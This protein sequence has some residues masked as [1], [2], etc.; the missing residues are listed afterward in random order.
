MRWKFREILCHD[1]FIWD[2]SQIYLNIYI[3]RW[4]DIFHKYFVNVCL[5][6]CTCSRGGSSMNVANYSCK[7]SGWS[8][9][10]SELL[11]C[12]HLQAARTPGF[13]VFKDGRSRWMGGTDS[14]QQDCQLRIY[15]TRASLH[16]F[17]A[18]GRELDIGGWRIVPILE[19]RW[20]GAHG[21]VSPQIEASL[22]I[23]WPLSG[24]R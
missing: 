6:S 7:K 14:W 10:C 19:S 23:H 20:L 8:S 15:F 2:A 22:L 4:S 13:R 3:F 9:L 5:H 11:I 18:I 16:C 21:L 1:F 12:G 24:L 17:A